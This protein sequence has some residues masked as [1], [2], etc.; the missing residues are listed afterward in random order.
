MAPMKIVEQSARIHAYG[1]DPT[2]RTLSVQ[3]KNFK[4][5][6]KPVRYDYQDVPPEV[7]EQLE[8][9]ESKGS[10]ITRNV[11][12]GNPFAFQKVDMSAAEEPADQAQA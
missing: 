2:S 12:N 11:V 6:A 9:A 3:F 1:Y 4:T 8:A 5:G 10:F 7:F